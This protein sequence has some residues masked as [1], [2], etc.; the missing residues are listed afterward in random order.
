MRLH[1]DYFKHQKEVPNVDM[2]QSYGWL[3]RNNFQLRFETESLLCAAQ[4]QALAT[5]YLSSKIWKQ[6]TDVKCCLCGEQNETIHH[7]VSGCK[8][9][10]ANQ[11]L[12]RH[13]QV[14]NYVHWCILKI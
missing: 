5:K 11:Y 6:G 7:I 9:L 1:G 4:E 3:H 13:N 10:A 2:C 12:H 14:G 8:L